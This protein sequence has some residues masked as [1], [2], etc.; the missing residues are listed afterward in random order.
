MFDTR[1]HTGFRFDET[2]RDSKA[3]NALLKQPALCYLRTLRRLTDE[4]PDYLIFHEPYVRL[5]IRAFLHHEGIFWDVDTLEREFR[6]VLA[7]SMTI[8][9]SIEK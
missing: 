2:R 1:I 8:L 9:R 7:D 5:R 4:D 3:V 6:R